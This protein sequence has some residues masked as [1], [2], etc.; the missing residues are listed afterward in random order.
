MKSIVRWFFVIGFSFVPLAHAQEVVTLPTRAGVTQSYF[1][2]RAPK[3]PQTV[4]VLFPGDVGL[5][6][7]RKEGGQ[8]KFDQGNFVV[9]ARAEFVKR[10]VVAAIVDAPSDR[11]SGLFTTGMSDD[12]RF[13]EKHSTDI[14]AVLAD[15]HKR[16][17]GVPLFLIGTSRGTVSAAPLAVKFSQQ[18]SGVVLTST[19]F[20]QTGTRTTNV[21]PCLSG[22]DFKT[23]KVPLLFVHHLSDGCVITPYED[24]E[25]LSKDY[26]LVTVSGGLA[27][28]SDE[29][30]PL[31]AHGFYGRESATIEEIVNWMLKKPYRSKV[32]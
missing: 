2:A 23:I 18:I 26:P 24:A 19:C 25:R 3:S 13:S 27:P 10:G 5:I 9:R 16:F 29:C 8:I 6:H 22:F 17:P 7:L 4:A 32:E 14:A 21:G 1:L 11:Q 31:S 12:F 20:R 15:L 28:K 30:E